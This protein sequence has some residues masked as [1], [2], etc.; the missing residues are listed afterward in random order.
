MA[1][2]SQV[3]DTRSGPWSSRMIDCLCAFKRAGFTFEEAWRFALEQNP[4]RGRD[5]GPE[6]PT[7]WDEELSPQEFLRRECCD[8]WH[9]RRKVLRH[10]VLPVH[11]DERALRRVA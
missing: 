9:G 5:L 2:A 6:R 1:L 8:A 10:L 4:P 3:T 7:L 11:A